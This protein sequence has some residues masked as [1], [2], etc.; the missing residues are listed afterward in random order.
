MYRAC[1][2]AMRLHAR[3]RTHHA[4]NSIECAALSRIYAHG[5]YCLREILYSEI[6]RVLRTRAATAVWDIMILLCGTRT[7]SVAA[8]ECCAVNF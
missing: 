3:T 2:R 7:R 1:V 6:R 5:W 4:C 8:A